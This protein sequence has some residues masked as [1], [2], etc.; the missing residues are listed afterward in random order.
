MNREMLQARMGYLTD[1]RP[2]ELVYA[3]G[4]AA[5]VQGCSFDEIPNSAEFE[6]CLIIFSES[7]NHHVALMLSK[8]TLALDDMVFPERFL[9]PAMYML[10]EREFPDRP[11]NKIKALREYSRLEIAAMKEARCA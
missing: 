8:E 1:G 9:K 7:W 11:L 10:D 2:F 6:C 3:G 5:G 4:A